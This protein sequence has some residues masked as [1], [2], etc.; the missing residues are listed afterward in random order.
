MQFKIGDRIKLGGRIGTIKSMGT[1]L[2]N[3]EWNDGDR[4]LSGL[5][6]EK[7]PDIQILPPEV[8]F[9]REQVEAIEAIMRNPAYNLNK[10]NDWLEERMVDKSSNPK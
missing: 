6:L 2:W 5:N 7:F 8:T 3:I 10:I 9:T 4:Y 1:I